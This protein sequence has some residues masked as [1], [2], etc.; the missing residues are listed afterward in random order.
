MGR[1]R[2]R[3]ARDGAR[4]FGTYLTANPFRRRTES[5]METTSGGCAIAATT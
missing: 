4:Y 2:E 1:S 5:G 3:P